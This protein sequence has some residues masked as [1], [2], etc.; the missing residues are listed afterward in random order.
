MVNK[1][2]QLSPFA[3][4]IFAQQLSLIFCWKFIIEYFLFTVDSIIRKRKHKKNTDIWL[5]KYQYLTRK[6]LIFEGG[7]RSSEVSKND[8]PLQSHIRALQFLSNCEV[9]NMSCPPWLPG[10]AQHQAQYTH[11]SCGNFWRE[12][13]L[14]W[15]RTPVFGASGAGHAAAIAAAQ[16]PAYALHRQIGAK[17]WLVSSIFLHW[18]TACFNWIVLCPPLFDCARTDRLN[19]DRYRS[20]KETSTRLHQN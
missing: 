19:K 15:R 2:C 9:T 18:Q 12:S 10:P 14:R 20:L 8:F 4:T 1:T 11:T 7:I 3:L 16:V 17:I 13:L 5:E 6:I